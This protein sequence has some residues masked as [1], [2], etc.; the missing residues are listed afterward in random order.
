MEPQ[1]SSSKP[2]LELS[3]SGMTCASCVR[4]VEKALKSVP[5]V[6]QVQVNLATETAKVVGELKTSP[7][8]LI[9]AVKDAGYD[10]VFK[11]KA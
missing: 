4:H 8:D 3:I 11:K 1:A 5:G 2:Y 9:Q 10:A 6:D 7:Q